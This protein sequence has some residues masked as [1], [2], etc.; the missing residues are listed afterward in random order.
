MAA[1]VVAR[2]LPEG[3]RPW[4]RDPISGPLGRPD[5][6]PAVQAGAG[7]AVSHARALTPS[8]P[9][10]VTLRTGERSPLSYLAQP[11]TDCFRRSLREAVEYSPRPPPERISEC[12]AA[13]LSAPLTPE[14]VRRW[15]TVCNDSRCFLIQ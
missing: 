5:G 6:R 1:Q 9:V 10:E 2:W 7:T 11:L 3:T 4:F 13:M 14:P 12:P 8:M 15:V